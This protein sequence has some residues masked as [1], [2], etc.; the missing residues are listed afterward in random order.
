MTTSIKQ[1]KTGLL[2]LILV[3]VLTLN[4]AAQTAETLRETITRSYAGKKSTIGLSIISSDGADTLSINGNRH[5]PMQSVFKF[6]IALTVLS[7]VQ[8]GKLALDQ[9][10]TI[11]KDQLLPGLFSPLREKYPEG[12][13]LPISEIIEY[14]VSKSDNA[15]CDALIRLVGSPLTVEE[16]FIK[17]GFQDISIKIN[18][19][20]MQSNWDLQFQNWITP[21]TASQILRSFYKNEHQQLSPSNHEFIW[22]T[23]KQTETGKNRLKGQLPP[24]STVAHKTGWS[25]TNKDG[26]TAA[27]NDIGIVFLPDGDYFFISVFVT[28][29][30][31]DIETNEKIIADICRLAWDYFAEKDKQR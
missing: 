9:R 28:D 30:K 3:L 15:A 2:I 29:S 14:A 10:V 31:E 1:T 7:Q 12:V 24:G 17:S 4:S 6:H 13:T 22:N 20:V 26:V 23:M 25:G 27:V 18:E 11:R 21:K 16:Y 8:S 5:F 19:E